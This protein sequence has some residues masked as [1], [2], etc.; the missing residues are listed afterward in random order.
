MK[1]KE[2]KSEESGKASRLYINSSKHCPICT[3]RS[4][5]IMKRNMAASETP[6]KRRKKMTYEGNIIA[7]NRHQK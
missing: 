4:A 6:Q 3:T 5:E 2:N 1:K 7:S